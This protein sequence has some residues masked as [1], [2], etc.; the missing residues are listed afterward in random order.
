[1]GNDH[2]RDVAFKFLKSIGHCLFCLRIKS[3]RSLVQDQEAWSGEQR[4]SEAQALPLTSTEPH[5]V[6]AH[7][8]VESFTLAAQ[9]LGEM[10]ALQRFPNKF[11]PD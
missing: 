10:C 7:D 8:G 5:A 6:F 11:V 3:T 4:P 1:M 2:K 9:H